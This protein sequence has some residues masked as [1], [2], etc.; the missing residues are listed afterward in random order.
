[1]LDH[2][3]QHAILRVPVAPGDGAPDQEG[4]GRTAWHD[5]Q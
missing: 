2:L 4:L 3:R 5:W 1:V